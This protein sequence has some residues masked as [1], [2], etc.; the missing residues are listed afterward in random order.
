[1]ADNAAGLYRWVIPQGATATLTA[2]WKDSNGSAYDLT[3]YTAALKAKLTTSDSTAL[4]DISTSG[5]GIVITAAQGKVACTLTPSE[6][7]ALDFDEA[8]YDL[9]LT[10]TSDGYVKRLLQGTVVLDREVTA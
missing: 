4:I 10:R 5:G 6:T 1:M 9:E 8:V 2:T 3:G 7:A